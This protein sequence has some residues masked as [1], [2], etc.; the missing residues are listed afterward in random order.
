LINLMIKKN[1]K[2]SLKVNRNNQG[3][4]GKEAYTSY[5]YSGLT[6]LA[7]EVKIVMIKLFFL[8]SFLP[9]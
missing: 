4:R 3:F 7:S 9:K 1:N 2:S 5:L 6:P 8:K